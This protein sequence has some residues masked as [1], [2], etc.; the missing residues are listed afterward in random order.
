MEE[1]SM[2][3]ILNQHCGCQLE[4]RDMAVPKDLLEAAY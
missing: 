4:A 1:M 2:H 3:R